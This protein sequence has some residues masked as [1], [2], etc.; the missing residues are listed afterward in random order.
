M[1]NLNYLVID[2]TK[3]KR[4][5]TEIQKLLGKTKLMA[6]VK[7]NA[8]GM[9]ITEIGKI[10][11][12]VGVNYFGVANIDEAIKLRDNLDNPEINIVV[13]NLYD[14]IQIL[15]AIEG[16]ITLPIFNFETAKLIDDCAQKLGKKE[17]VWIKIDTGLG[18]LGL[19]AQNAYPIIQKISNLN[20]LQIEGIYSTLC[21][22]ETSNQKQLK[23]FKDLLTQLKEVNIKIPIKSLISSDGVLEFPEGYL[24]LARVGIML[25]GFYP[26]EKAKIEQKIKLSPIVTWNTYLMET[27]TLEKEQGYLYRQK[28]QP[29]NSITIG[30]LPIG[31]SNGLNPQIVNGGK[32]LIAGRKY[33]FVGQVT[34]NNSF[35]DLRNKPTVGK[36]DLVTIIGQQENSEITL[37]EYAKIVGQSE[38][39]V[40]CG[41]PTNTEK[42]YI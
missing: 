23:I 2:T 12:K 32:A 37:Q 25:Y 15:Q 5:L 39:Q 8:Y 26:S 40:L 19:N 4:N 41:F 31:Y 21:E 6:M 1:N 11:I 17:K 27:R 24:N 3:L 33:P 30:I 18:R 14:D 22:G 29:T 9:G 36:G 13:T 38:Y 42:V 7:A 35:I 28:Y 20:N 10:L 16:K 34:M